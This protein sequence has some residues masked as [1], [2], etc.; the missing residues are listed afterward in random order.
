MK[1]R[2]KAIKTQALLSRSTPWKSN[3]KPL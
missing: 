1:A 3:E 2:N